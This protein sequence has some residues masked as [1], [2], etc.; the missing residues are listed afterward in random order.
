MVESQRIIEISGE[1]Y[2]KAT[3]QVLDMLD[4]LNQEEY[5]IAQ[6]AKHETLDDFSEWLK[7]HITDLLTEISPRALIFRQMR[8]LFFECVDFYAIAKRYANKYS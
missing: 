7:Q 5:I 3:W 2:T 1:E 4:Y 8:V 6:I